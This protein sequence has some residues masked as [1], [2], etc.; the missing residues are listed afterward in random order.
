MDRSIEIYIDHGWIG[1]GAFLTENSNK[2]W[3][4]KDLR[5]CSK[6]MILDQNIFQFNY[7]T[8]HRHPAIESTQDGKLD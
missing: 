5:W 1:D 4:Y 2:N 8:K 7:Y 3:Q 6:I